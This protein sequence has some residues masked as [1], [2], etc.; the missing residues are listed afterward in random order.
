MIVACFTQLG[1]K[2]KVRRGT[3]TSQKTVY[4]LVCSFMS[5]VSRS[6]QFV[7]QPC[8]SF[9]FFTSA[10]LGYL[11]FSFSTCSLLDPH[12]AGKKGILIYFLV[13]WMSHIFFNYTF[14][15]G[16]VN[17]M[18]LTARRLVRAT[19]SL[20]PTGWLPFNER[21]IQPVIHSLLQLRWGKTFSL[22]FQGSSEKKS[23]LWGTSSRRSVQPKC[24]IETGWN[25]KFS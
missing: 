1:E 6:L 3:P 5:T 16:C 15:C 18:L 8:F 4:R 10:K 19:L 23:D 14:L 13:D 24:R 20:P 12:S 2:S 11:S 21:C 22:C 25:F 17:C 7:T 9:F